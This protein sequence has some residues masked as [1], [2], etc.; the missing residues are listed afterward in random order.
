M[1]QVLNW[2]K[3]NL[4]LIFAKLF[5]FNSHSVNINV[6][7]KYSHFFLLNFLKKWH[8]CRKYQNERTYELY[9]NIVLTINNKFMSTLITVLEKSN[10][11]IWEKSSLPHFFETFFRFPFKSALVPYRIMSLTRVISCT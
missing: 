9:Q 5:I 2:V 6:I 7:K 4:L 3:N 1:K 11:S 10:I 8:F